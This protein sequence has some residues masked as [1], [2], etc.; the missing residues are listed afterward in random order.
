MEVLLLSCLQAQLIAGRI[1]K[2]EI[3]N[4]IKNDLIIELKQNTSKDCK[5]NL[6]KSN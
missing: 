3:S 5:I 2:T 1:I 4:H 6:I